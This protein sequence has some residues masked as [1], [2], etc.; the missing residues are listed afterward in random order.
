M[1]AAQCR[2]GLVFD[3]QASQPVNS[4][5]WV[6]GLINPAFVYNPSSQGAITSLA[7]SIDQSEMANFTYVPPVPDPARLLILQG[8]NYYGVIANGTFPGVGIFS[9]VSA[10][11]LTASSLVFV[12]MTNSAIVDA[13]GNT[14]QPGFTDASLHPDFSA[15]GGAIEFGQADIHNFVCG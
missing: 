5:G 6:L 14:V 9:P 11:G 2:A 1:G 15:A 7:F 4:F 13:H 10:S 3:F 8:G 12:N